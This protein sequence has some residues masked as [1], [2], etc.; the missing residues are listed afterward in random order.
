[1][2]KGI[3]HE[4]SPRAEKVEKI[5]NFIKE[6]SSDE[7]EQMWITL[8]CMASMIIAH[9][10]NKENAMMVTE[11]MMAHLLEKI[12]GYEEFPLSH[13]KSRSATVQ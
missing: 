1:M 10:K 8:L 12:D 13:W 11:I 7:G 9:T 2:K 6:I 4:D 5:F 3:D